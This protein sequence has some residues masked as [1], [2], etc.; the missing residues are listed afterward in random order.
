MIGSFTKG[1]DI[2]ATNVKVINIETKETLKSAS[3]KGEGAGSILQ[4]QIDELSRKIAEGMGLSAHQISETAR[5]VADIT[6]SSLG[7]YEYYLKGR[8]AQERQ[9]DHTTA[10]RM[11][12]K[13]IAL[14]STFASAHLWLGI[15]LADL[16]LGKEADNELEIAKRYSHRA[17]EIERLYIDAAYADRVEKDSAKCIRIYEQILESHPNDKRIHLAL[18]EYLSYSDSRRALFHF[19]KA[20]EADPENAEILN[21]IGYMYVDLGNLEKALEYIGRNASL[22]PDSPNPFDSKGEVYFRMGWLDNALANFKKA[23]EVR[24]DFYPAYMRAAYVHALREE[25]GEAMALIDTMLSVAQSPAY[26]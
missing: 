18:G 12:E 24:R 22:T 23:I 1:D 16:G 14:D 7:A 10:R 20:L 21:A 9:W 17:G 3:S 6:S 13:A 25:Y 4:H 2:F 5:P 15:S 26:R 19:E 8:N 11:F